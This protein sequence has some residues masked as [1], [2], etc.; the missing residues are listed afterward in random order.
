MLDLQPDHSSSLFYHPFV[1]F[2]QVRESEVSLLDAS[3]VPKSNILVVVIQF[4]DARQDRCIQLECLFLGL[5]EGPICR[6]RCRL[7]DFDLADRQ[8]QILD[9]IL[10]T[11]VE[12]NE[13]NY[14][15]V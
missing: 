11:M 13:C 12:F 7:Y 2:V 4:I 6:V 3:L 8:Q 10:T 14:W 9:V 5:S 1:G 15:I